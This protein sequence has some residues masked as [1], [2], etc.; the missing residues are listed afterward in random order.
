MQRK[1]K[2]GIFFVSK[3]GQ[4]FK[5]AGFLARELRRLGSEVS[6]VE[7]ASPSDLL[8]DLRRFDAVLVAAPMYAGRYGKLV[9]RFVRMH[10]EELNRKWSTAFVSVCLTV[11]ADTPSAYREAGVPLQAFLD[12][13]GWKPGRTASFAGALWYRKYN[14]FIRWVMKR[15]SRKAGGPL[16]TSRNHELTRWEA[17]SSF[18]REFQ[19]AQEASAATNPPAGLPLSP[20]GPTSSSSRDAAASGSSSYRP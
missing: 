9:A 4:T 8:V 6:L 15:I 11:A 17:V 2:I 1:K 3:Y 13:T 19:G 20:P 16:D 7:L 5:I 14:P 18:A 12:E 10:I